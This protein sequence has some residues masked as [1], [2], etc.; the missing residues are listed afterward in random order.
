MVDFVL[1]IVGVGD[2]LLQFGDILPS[3]A[4]I[5]RTEIHVERFVLKI[6]HW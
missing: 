6:L 2:E 4:D 5:E 3:F 1:L